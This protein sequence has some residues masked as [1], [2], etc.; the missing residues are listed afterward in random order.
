MWNAWKFK[1]N[2]IARRKKKYGEKINDGATEGELACLLKEVKA[3]LRMD[4]PDEY[5]KFLKVVNGIE[6]NG[7]I[8]YGV[9]QRLL[10][11]E[12]NQT[13]DGLIDSNQVWYENEWDE[14]Y[15]FLGDSSISWYVYDERNKRYCELDKPSGDEIEEFS[16]W[17]AMIERILKDA[18]E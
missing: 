11:R 10:E 6:H 5:I 2:E 1:L 17:R 18:L 8:L 13:V 14:Q 12:P 15:L 16:S 9:D 3:E 4:I 7:F